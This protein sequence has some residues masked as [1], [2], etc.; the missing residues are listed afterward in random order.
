MGNAA[1]VGLASFAEIRVHDVISG[2]I[3]RA[4]GV[5]IAHIGKWRV[6]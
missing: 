6:G 1:G 3:S 5:F 2:T 4:P